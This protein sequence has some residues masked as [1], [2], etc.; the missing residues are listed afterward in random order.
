M[1]TELED[2]KIELE[3][4]ME[5]LC[6]ADGERCQLQARIEE[7]EVNTAALMLAAKNLVVTVGFDAH[8]IDT[9][10]YSTEA[11]REL[12]RL[13]KICRGGMHYV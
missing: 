13:L 11:V 12:T 6:S 5:T 10:K 2:T 8:Y 7:M 4:A 3:A 9:D 1:R